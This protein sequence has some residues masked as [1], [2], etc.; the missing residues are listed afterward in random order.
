MSTPFRQT[1]T[2]IEI[3][4][5]SQERSMLSM[6]PE[7]LENVGAVGVDPAADRL[8][9][10]AY[11]EDPVSNA[12][13]HEMTDSDLALARSDDRIRFS[14]SLDTGSLDED[15]AQMWLRV[16]GDA[17]LTLAAR[18]GIE[19]EAWENDR[20]LSE[21]IEGAMLSYLGYLQ[22]ALIEVLTSSL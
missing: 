13:F 4:L 15:G 19:D 3:S 5:T 17:R 11:P 8:N 9:P 21:S 20:S 6:L 16:L 18:M 10:A 2:T 7:L 14:D 22:N 1:G 12:N